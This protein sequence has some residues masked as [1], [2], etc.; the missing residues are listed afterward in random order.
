[1]RP[2]EGVSPSKQNDRDAALQARFGNSGTLASP[3]PHKYASSTGDESPK[4]RV[5]DLGEPP[6][7]V[8]TSRVAGGDDAEDGGDDAEEQYH[9]EAEALLARIRGSTDPLQAL[10]GAVAAGPSVM[11][12]SS[13]GGGA[14][15]G[16]AR[17]AQQ[18]K[19]SALSFVVD[20]QDPPTERRNPDR[21]VTVDD[22]RYYQSLVGGEDEAPV[23]A[24]RGGGAAKGPGS[25]EE[26]A[27]RVDALLSELLP[28]RKVRQAA[29]KQGK[30][31][32]AGYSQKGNHGGHA[33]QDDDGYEDRGLSAT[34]AAKLTLNS[35]R[36]TLKKLKERHEQ[37]ETALA[38]GQKSNKAPREF[39]LNAPG[40]FGNAS[41]RQVQ[42]PPRAKRVSARDSMETATHESSALLLPDEQSL[43]SQVANLKKELKRATERTQRLT[44]HSLTLGQTSDQQKLEIA[45]LKED[46]RVAHM[47]IDAKEARAADAMRLRKK[48][49]KKVKALEEAVSDVSALQA[50]NERLRDRE[51][52][53]IEAVEALSSQNEDLIRKLKASMARELELSAMTGGSG[54]QGSPPRAQSDTRLQ[55]SK[56][57]VMHSNANRGA[58]K[59]YGNGRQSRTEHLPRL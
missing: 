45:R 49:Q 38:P 3:P 11:R 30:K 9:N 2:L 21:D 53:L 58:S 22:M 16:S 33:Q 14:V 5:P 19:A 32:N 59:A 28:D 18:T 20:K 13:G 55:R 51:A 31:V 52:A 25:V 48:A 37:M 34:N 29:V 46:L 40:Y 39:G 47:D 50:D 12:A 42:S 36:D 17:K 1:M 8:V 10:G 43:T 4:R 15:A 41:K 56:G 7:P 54:N 35:T 24:R 6:S 57:K 27:A 23:K 44:E 26:N